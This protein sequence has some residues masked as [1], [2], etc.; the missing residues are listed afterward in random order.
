MRFVG[1]PYQG[2]HCKESEAK[3][4]IFYHEGIFLMFVVNYAVFFTTNAYFLAFVVNY[5]R[6]FG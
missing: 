2:S 6:F 4:V 1:L 5:R 3:H